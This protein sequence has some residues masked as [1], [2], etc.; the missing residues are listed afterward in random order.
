MPR[1][2]GA[3]PTQGVLGAGRKEEVAV[4]RPS[5]GW[6][7]GRGRGPQPGPRMA[8]ANPPLDQELEVGA[9]VGVGDKE[10]PS[11]TGRRPCP[12]CLL[13]R[14]QGEETGPWPGSFLS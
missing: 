4:R 14:D 11:D 5:Q 6:G 8:Q 3:G 13:I 9:G 1:S 7:S 10:D 12:Q 2:P